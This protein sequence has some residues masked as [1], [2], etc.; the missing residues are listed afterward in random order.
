L[1]AG[2]RIALAGATGT[3]GGEVLAVM[4]EEGLA[5]AELALYG[6]ERSLGAEIEYMGQRL[7]VE[8]DPPQLRHSDLLIVCTKSGPAL[9][10]V[11]EALRAEVPCLDC[12]GSLT[13]SSDVP[14]VV[15]DLGAHDQVQTA[16]LITVPTGAALS[17]ALVLS[18]LQRR[19][20]LERVVGT[21]LHS[22]SAAGRRGIA[23][24]SDQTVA[25]LNQQA[26]AD[27]TAFP[28]PL[29]FDCHPHGPE[30]DK[31]ALAPSESRIRET[32]H[33]L[34]GPDVGIGLT[35][36][37]VPAF[38]GEASAL[39]VELREPLLAEEAIRVLEAAPG[40]EVWEADAPGTRDPVGRDVVLVGRVRTDDSLP[41]PGKGLLIWA[42]ADPVRLAASN[43]V[44]VIRSRFGL[45]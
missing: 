27:S 29:A 7:P 44:K 13:A 17:C 16:P 32:L 25:L 26:A 40:V 15:A 8:V 18:A 22:A 31:D 6:G 10:L 36:V 39:A 23:D 1:S 34:L 24:L 45:D 14:L 42:A 11:R 38:A 35:S 30:D 21:V 43:A 5:V 3:L 4:E 20:G 41:T 2:L 33:R 37:Q 9:D 12:S 28:F 19:A